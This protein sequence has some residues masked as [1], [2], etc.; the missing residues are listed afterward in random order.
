M[1]L[2]EQVKAQ[3]DAMNYEQLLRRWRFAPIGDPIFQGESGKYFADV[4]FRKKA[5][6]N[7]DAVRASKNV[8]WD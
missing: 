6:P 7:T 8:G 5:D 4:M 1:K 3:I 2:T